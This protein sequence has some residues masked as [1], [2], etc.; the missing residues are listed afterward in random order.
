MYVLINS[1]CSFSFCKIREIQFEEGNCSNIKAHHK[2]YSKVMVINT[3]KRWI[4]E[5]L[6]TMKHERFKLD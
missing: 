6:K 3:Q 1:D 5:Q 2:F 4:E